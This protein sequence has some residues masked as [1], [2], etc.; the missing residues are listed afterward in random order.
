MM[1]R[2]A[3]SIAVGVDVAGMVVCNE[4]NAAGAAKNTALEGGG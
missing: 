3:P 2:T 4:T 1:R